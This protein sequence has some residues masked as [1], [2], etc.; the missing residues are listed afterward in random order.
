MKPVNIG[1]MGQRITFCR[2]GE[3]E[4]EM[5]QTVVS[6]VPYKTVWADVTG[7]SGLEKSEAGKL[8]A[9]THY[10]VRIR[11][12]TDIRQEM[13]IRWKERVLEIKSIINTYGRNRILELDC[14]EYVKEG[15][16]ADVADDGGGT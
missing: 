16:G 9:E 13:L 1:Y 7:K 2:M 5:G 3:A 14:T 8:T 10:I 11:Y 15:G 6:P 4:D 12:R